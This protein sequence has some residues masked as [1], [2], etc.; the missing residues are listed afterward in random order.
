A[1]RRILQL[2]DQLNAGFQAVTEQS[3]AVLL[4]FSPS[5]QQ[6]LQFR[7]NIRR[8]QPSI[9]TLLQVQITSAQYLA[10]KPLTDLPAPIAQ[11]GIAFEKDIACV[12]RAMANE[13]SGQPAAT[14]PD[15]RTSA[16]RFRE[17]I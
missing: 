10:Q 16:T 2:R 7:E 5:R 6:K 1:I 12:M 14:V 4:D 13:V 15:I 9:R 3:D 11:F 8:W 17:E